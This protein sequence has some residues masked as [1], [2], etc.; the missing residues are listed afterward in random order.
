MKLS[1][2]IDIIV[3]GNTKNRKW[4][5]KRIKQTLNDCELYLREQYPNGDDTIGIIKV[6]KIK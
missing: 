4:C 5:A 2:E 1:A 3:E 6:K